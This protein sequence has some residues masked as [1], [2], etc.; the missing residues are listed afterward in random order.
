MSS[1]K[2]LPGEKI[3][4]C[5]NLDKL[6]EAHHNSDLQGRISKARY[7][8]NFQKVGLCFARTHDPG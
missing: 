7:N 6:I 4:G 5:E 1:T 3:R 8:E 2:C